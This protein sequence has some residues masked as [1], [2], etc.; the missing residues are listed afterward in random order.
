MKR[1]LMVAVCMVFTANAFAVTLTG[2]PEVDQVLQNRSVE[3]YPTEATWREETRL[4]SDIGPTN[5]FVIV[6]NNSSKSTYIT[7]DRFPRLEVKPGYTA[8]VVY[9]RDQKKWVTARNEKQPDGMG[10]VSPPGQ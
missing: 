3:F 9:D 1:M 6:G 8:T 4:P 10:H 2:I 7:G 5:N